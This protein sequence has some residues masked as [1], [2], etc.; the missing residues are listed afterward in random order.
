MRQVMRDGMTE[1]R[2]R[3]ADVA[4]GRSV[5]AV[6]ALSGLQ[7][8]VTIAGAQTWVARVHGATLEATGPKPRGDDLATLLTVARVDRWDSGVIAEASEAA[9]LEALIERSARARGIDTSRPFPFLIEGE[10]VTLDM[11]V[12]N[13]YCP[14]G[15]DPSTMN[16][17]PWRWTGEHPGRVLIVGFF[18]PDSAGV[19]THH[20]TSVHA[21]AL[22]TLDDR[23]VT[24]HVDSFGVS[25]GVVLK[26]PAAP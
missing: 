14:R 9:A 22:L 23:T 10:R 19:M 8:E 25:A 12:V 13:G 15:V 5:Y 11:H 2:V 18:A 3:L 6:G 21:H 20:G 4:S 16:A 1:P 24:G 17:Q 26:T 7:G